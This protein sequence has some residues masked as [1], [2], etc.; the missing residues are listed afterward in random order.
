MR[1]GC[2]RCAIPSYYPPQAG[3]K[4]VKSRPTPWSVSD[5][6]RAYN[7][8]DNFERGTLHIEV[9][10]SIT[11]QQLV[12]IFEQLQRDH[13]LPQVLRTD[14]SP[15]FLCEAFVQRVKEPRHAAGYIAHGKPNQNATPGALTAPSTTMSWTAP[16]PAAGRRSR[17]TALVDGRIHEQRPHDNPCDLVLAARRQQSAGGFYSVVLPSKPTNLTIPVVISSKVSA[18]RQRTVRSSRRLML[19][20]API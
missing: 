2:A 5:G 19:H 11:S 6:F 10:T 16:A 4:P 8:I 18:A 7:I 9:G 20:N 17:S 15:G 13:G 14:N 1:I 3:I 12:R